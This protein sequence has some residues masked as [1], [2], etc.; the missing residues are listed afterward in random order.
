MKYPRIYRAVMSSPWAI[1][2]EKLEAIIELIEFK[3]AGGMYSA[4][5]LQARTGD[6][7]PQAS[8][9]GGI[10][11]LPIMGV[12]SQRINMMGELSGPGGTSTEQF[13]Q[14]LDAAVA[15]PSISAIVFNIDS[16]GGSVFGV[17]ELANKIHAAR[18][19]KPIVAVANSLAASAAY[20]L[21]AAADEVVV[22]PSGE[23]GSIGVYGMHQDVSRAADAAGY[24]HTFISAGKYKTE[25][26]SFEPLGDE[27][28][29]AM[30]S[31]VDDY[32]RAFTSAVARGRGVS[33]ADVRNGF[34]EGRVVGAQ[35]AVKLGMADRVA[36]LDETIARLANPR[37][38]ARV[39]QRTEDDQP[40]ISA[41]DE[42]WRACEAR[43]AERAIAAEDAD[44]MDLDY[45]R[46]R[47][48]LHSV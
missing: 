8:T 47:G 3:A 18:G 44:L 35:Q 21:A 32:Y 45:R 2:Q 17:E 36:T 10:Q 34:G 14:Q 48:R 27:A 25:G 19:T 33:A 42:G 31:R 12:I 24:T 46:R 26:N 43:N 7:G 28:R 4:E 16:P 9:T 40:P 39:G 41:F 5:E 13:G 20:W 11:V 37:Q 38:R 29:A 15:D 30:Q 23:V 6:S 22:T 1:Q